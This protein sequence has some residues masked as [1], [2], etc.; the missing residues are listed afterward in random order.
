MLD[1]SGAGLLGAV[2]GTAIAALLYRPLSAL[3]DR[4]L[5][6]ALR[7]DGSAERELMERAVLFRI[8][9]ATDILVFASAGYWLGASMGG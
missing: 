5:A 2:I 6:K 9:L 4:G 1:I 8:V 3:V 7:S